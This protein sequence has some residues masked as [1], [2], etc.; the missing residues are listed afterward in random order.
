MRRIYVIRLVGYVMGLPPI[1]LH[2]HAQHA[3][4]WLL[5]SV[6]VICLIWP[7]VAY[8]QAK[9]SAQPIVRERVNL[10]CDSAWG[11]WLAVAIQLAP[12]GTIVILL[13]FALD[14]MAVGGWRLFLAGT[15]ASACAI[16]LGVVILGAPSVLI[17]AESYIAF[18]WLPVAVVYPLVL[19]KTTHDVSAKLIERSA[20]LRELSERDSLTGLV[21][22]GTV[23]GSLQALLAEAE[24]AQE[25]ISVL[26]IDLDG[27]K[28]VNDA[29]GHNVGDELLVKMAKRLA[30]CAHDDEIVARYGGDEFVIVA[31]HSKENGADRRS[32]LSEAV[33][34]AVSTPIDVGGHELLLGASIGVSSFPD[35]GRDAAGLLHSADI[36]MYAAKNRGRNCYELYQPRMRAEADARLRLSARLRKAI[37]SGGLRLHYQPQVDMRTGELRGLEALVRWNDVDFGEI[38]PSDFIAVAETAG[39]VSHLGEWVLG[40]ACGQVVAWQRLGVRLPRISVN[41]SPLQLQRADVVETFERILNETRIDP[42]CVELEVTETALMRQPETA[43]RRLGEFRRAG[44][45]IAIDDFG[46]G[47]SSLG[48]LRTLPIDRIKIDRAFV[49][50]IGAGD[51]GAIATA[52]VTLAKTLGLAVIAEGV[53]TV[54]QR[55]FLLS[56]GCVDAQGYLYSKP[57][58]VDAAT[59]LLVDG[60]T[61]PQLGDAPC[62]GQGR[63]VV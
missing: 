20:R 43:A 35:D 63:I 42:A 45:T 15:L 37:E 17:G 25:R 22:R 58:D 9:R 7:H 62:D 51:S 48:Q 5:A 13:M 32:I 11:G 1:L 14:N 33:L 27:F 44:I 46:I 8:L 55:D 4:A 54:A 56:L 60:G 38:Q 26:F 24:G 31:R 36:A 49:E 23:A 59:R 2:L 57:L 6:L 29:L 53:E 21:N 40:A 3:G 39:L 28:T 16:F 19:A 61:L 34:Q 47:Y 12:I 41:V 50:G 52:I 18:A 10:V 30:A